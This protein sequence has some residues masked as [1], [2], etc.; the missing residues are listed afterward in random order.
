[1]FTNENFKKAQNWILRENGDDF[2]DSGEYC[3]TKDIFRAR[4]DRMYFD[5]PGNSSRE[6]IVAITGEIGNN[7]FD[8]NL[9]NWRDIPGV[10]FKYDFD[11]SLIVLADRGQG[12]RATIEKV[13][14]SVKSDLDA[15]KT[16]FLENIS[17]RAPEQRGNGLKFVI[18]ET[19]ENNLFI[20]FH[21]GNAIL[22][23]NQ[24]MEFE[25]TRINLC[26]CLAII[27]FK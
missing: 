18:K 1:M 10:Y 27:K 9:G 14:P 15:L 4:L 25:N 13:K 23:S 8:H 19:K 3:K 7:S 2:L 17:G 6:V 26:G 11:N 20:Y 16:A 12:I 21:S 24:K 5:L 22:K